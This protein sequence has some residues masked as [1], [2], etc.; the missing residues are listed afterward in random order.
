[1]KKNGFTLV[2]LLGVIAILALLATVA[3]PA[4]IS[5]SNKIKGNMYDAKV[6]LIKENAILYAEKNNI[7]GTSIRSVN[8]LC[9]ACQHVNCYDF[10]KTALL[11]PDD[12]LDWVGCVKNPV[13][14]KEMGKKCYMKIT[15][16]NGRYT[17]DFPVDSKGN[18]SADS[19]C[20]K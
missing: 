11:N 8:Y 6:K 10:Q 17:V 9:N 7:N 5:L 14:N 20:L 1:M 16:N 19:A 4:I 3:T 15:K 2:E 12:G 13:N 18:P